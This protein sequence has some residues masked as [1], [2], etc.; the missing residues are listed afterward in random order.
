MFLLFDPSS[1]S[2]IPLLSSYINNWN[3][4][5]CNFPEWLWTWQRSNFYPVKTNHK[6]A[7][8]ICTANYNLG[9]NFAHF[10]YQHGSILA[11][12]IPW[13]EEPGG[14]QSMG[15]LRVGHDW[16][17]SFSLFTFIHWRGKWQPTPMF[18]PGESQGWGSLL[19]CHLWDR[20]VRHDWSDLAAA[21][22][23]VLS[24]PL[25]KNSFFSR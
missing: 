12:K 8:G 21:A 19:G 2:F 17:T 10:V 1:Y 15:S 24:W 7:P 14:L 3:K 9:L 13:M 22:A 5:L 18:L 20:T 6:I 4:A 16:G 25:Y 23:A 11:W